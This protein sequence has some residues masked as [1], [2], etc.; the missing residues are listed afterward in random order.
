MPRPQLRLSQ[1]PSPNPQ[2]PVTSGHAIQVVSTILPHAPSRTS[3]P[4][5]RF[6]VVFTNGMGD[7]LGGSLSQT[8]STT[9]PFPEK[10]LACFTGTYPCFHP[11]M[12]N[13]P[14]NNRFAVSFDLQ[15]RQL[16][17]LQYSEFMWRQISRL[18]CRYGPL[19]P[20]LL[21]HCLFHG[22]KQATNDIL[23]ARFLSCQE[24]DPIL[25]FTGPPRHRCVPLYSSVMEPGRVLPP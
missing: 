5:V 25:P 18:L 14:I 11:G 21:V 15:R 6:F 19:G 17:R 8:N 9:P 10:V 23:L 1:L 20:L 22:Y 13:D 2:R 3:A 12:A 24:L 7:T 16:P 4:R